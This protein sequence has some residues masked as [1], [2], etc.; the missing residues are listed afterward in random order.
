MSRD[1]LVLNKNYYAIHVISYKKA[2]S[3]MYQGI[4][5]AVDDN[6][7]SYSF[8]DWKELSAAMKE[9]PSEN[10]FISSPN[11]RIAVPDI[12]VLTK[13][14]RLPRRDVKFTRRNIYEHYK[15]T[16]C[17][18][19]KTFKTSELNLDHVFPKSRGGKTDWTNI[20]TSCL[21]C[22]SR[23]ADRTPEEA[24][25]ALLI[26]PS[27]PNWKGARTM[28]EFPPNVTMKVSWQKIIDTNYWDSELRT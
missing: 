24:G 23:K 2:I 13:Y 28:V 17:Y 4:A 25:M 6:Y 10:G 14:D 20:V 9:A 5:N 16:C 22:N 21:Q 3:L 12:I 11:F 1:I 8:E 15:Y 18:C 7:R 26:K 27:R 19:D